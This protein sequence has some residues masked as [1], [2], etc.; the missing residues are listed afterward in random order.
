MRSQSRYTPRI[1]RLAQVEYIIDGID[2]K[3]STTEVGVLLETDIRSTA[4]K[5]IAAYKTRGWDVVEETNDEG[6]IRV[7]IDYP[8]EIQK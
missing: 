3:L 4:D 1:A 6:T 5:I 8:E 2:Q 7:S